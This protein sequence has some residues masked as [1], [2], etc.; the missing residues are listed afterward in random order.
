VPDEAANRGGRPTVVTEEKK[1]L[2]LAIVREGLPL[3]GAARA[4]GLK[5]STVRG[6]RKR[7]MG[8][9]TALGIARGESIRS[10]VGSI[11][12]AAGSEWKAAAWLLAKIDPERWGK[13]REEPRR[14]EAEAPG[15]VPHLV[16]VV[17]ESRDG[18]PT[19]AEVVMQLEES[20]AENERLRGQGLELVSLRA[21][22][23]PEEWALHDRMIAAA[24]QLTA[25]Q[26]R[27]R[28][29]GRPPSA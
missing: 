16:P 2:M 10:L 21:D 6:F 15:T 11:R 18:I 1:A 23:S 22:A 29:E 5:P 14:R 20:R 26:S 4:V 13:Q 9:A 25:L 24:E 27:R 19:L 8:F 28:M 3:D 12:A 7:N 17:V